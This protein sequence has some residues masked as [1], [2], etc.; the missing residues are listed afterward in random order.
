VIENIIQ[1]Q[2]INIMKKSVFFLIIFISLISCKEIKDDEPTYP[3]LT[4][5][6]SFDK[7]ILADYHI[8]SIAFDNLGNA[9]IGTFKQGLI[10]YNSNQTIVYNS[11]NSIISD[12][13]IW[14]IAID[15]KNNVWIGCNGLIKYNGS[16]FVRFDSNNS[17]IPEDFVS[18][19]SIDSK[20]NIWFSSSRFRQ[21]GLVKYDGTK[22]TVYTPDNSEL[23]A[24]LI[25]DIAID[26][27][28]NVW[29][30]LSEVVTNSYLVKIFED[31]WKIYTSDDLGF[32]PYYLGNIQINSQ[33]KLFASIDYSLSSSM[34]NNSPHIFTFDGTSTEKLLS[35]TYFYVRF[36]TVDNQDNIW[37]SA[38]G[39]TYAI[40]D[41]KEWTICESAFEGSG[42]SVIE[43]AHDNKI[44]IGTGNGIR[45]SN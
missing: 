15:S 26:K 39:G 7:Q 8:T 34:L 31:K 29:L 11:E 42:I 24:N 19:I 9:W 1:T 14:D 16:E 4:L 23:P 33:N 45:I 30:A 21:G 44:W 20:D 2:K 38:F 18:S 40:Y 27:N 10:K 43:Q 25:Q 6:V 3:P 17:P 36:I 41:G 5:P 37:C 28:D 32:I 12:E 13:T 35:D 22:W